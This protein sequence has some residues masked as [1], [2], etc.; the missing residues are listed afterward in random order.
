LAGLA[1]LLR[2][3]EKRVVHTDTIHRST[4]AGRTHLGRDTDT[5]RTV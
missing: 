5:N 3:P 1:G 2:R 4:D